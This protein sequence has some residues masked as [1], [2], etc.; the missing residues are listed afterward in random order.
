MTAGSA[1]P[2]RWTVLRVMRERRWSRCPGPASSRRKCGIPSEFVAGNEPPGAPFRASA[3]FRTL[4]RQH[5]AHGWIKD[6]ACIRCTA[7][8]RCE[9]AD[10]AVTLVA[11]LSRWPAAFLYQ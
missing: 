1:G 3:T 8:Q 11:G 5:G 6:T 10:T 2:P 4:A 7:A 9:A